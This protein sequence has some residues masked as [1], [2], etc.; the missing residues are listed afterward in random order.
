[1]FNATL[2]S[3]LGIFV[4]PMWLRLLGGTNGHSLPLGQVILDLVLW[5][6]LPLLVGQLLRPLFGAFALRHKP[7]ISRIDRGTIL[8]LIYTSFCDSFHAGVWVAHG[9]WSVLIASLLSLLLLAIVMTCTN[10]LSNAAKLPVEDRIVGVFCGSKKTLA[11][12]VPMARLMFGQDPALSLILLPLMIY[13][14][15][16]LVVCGW[17]AGRWGSRSDVP[18][19]R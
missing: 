2:S 8:L 11:S 14:P 19:D 15:L 18:A 17:F 13:H 12:G 6:L 3:I 16:Q 7:V 10:A 4:T 9:L 1:V 5:L